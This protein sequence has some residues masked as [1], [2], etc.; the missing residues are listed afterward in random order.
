MIYTIISFWTKI[1]I[2]LLINEQLKNIDY[3]NQSKKMIYKTILKK[4]KNIELENIIEFIWKK[5]F[6]Y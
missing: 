3:S 4:I 2:E 1:F 5:I 6:L